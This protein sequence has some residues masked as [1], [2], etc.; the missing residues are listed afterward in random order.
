MNS[1]ADMSSDRH[2]QI[3]PAPRPGDALTGALSRAFGNDNCMPDGWIELLA[4]LDEAP[5]RRI[6][7]GG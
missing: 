5:G 6:N 3:V 7:S 4:A 2:M 1:N